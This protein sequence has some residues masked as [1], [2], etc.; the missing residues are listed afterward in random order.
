MKCLL[1]VFAKQRDWFSPISCQIGLPHDETCADQ[2]LPVRPNASFLLFSCSSRHLVKHIRLSFSPSS[3]SFAVIVPLEATW[4]SC[5]LNFI[6]VGCAT[7]IAPT[8]SWIEPCSFVLEKKPSYKASCMWHSF[9]CCRRFLRYKLWEKQRARLY[10]ALSTFGSS[11]ETTILLL[12]WG[13]RRSKS[14]SRTYCHRRHS[15]DQGE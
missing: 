12:N 3:R 7:H 6:L 15:T 9:F 10:Y 4:V 14:S 2:A 8:L 1:T 5:A 11:K 13:T